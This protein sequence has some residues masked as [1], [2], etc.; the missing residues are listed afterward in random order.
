M[1]GVDTNVLL[2]LVVN[3]DPAQND[4]VKAFFAK[5]S[6]DDPAYVGLVVIAE[7]TWLLGRHYGYSKTQ[8]ADVL[9]GLLDSV[10]LVIERPELVQEAALLSREPRI[11]FADV[12]IARL[13]QEHQCTTTVTFDRNAAKR[14][15]GMDLLA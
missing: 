3:D 13:G 5:R 9:I 14:I 6:V 12:L 2:R 7:F 4:L 10:D 1:I 8:I 15:A 11:D